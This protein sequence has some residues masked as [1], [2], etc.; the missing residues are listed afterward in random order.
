MFGA[1]DPSILAA[2]GIKIGPY[3]F[4][5]LPLTACGRPYVLNFYL[6]FSSR[7]KS[8][9][10]LF[11]LFFYNA[12]AR[13]PSGTY[14]QTPQKFSN[15]SQKRHMFRN[16]RGLR[17]FGVFLSA[18]RCPKS[19][20]LTTHRSRAPQHFVKCI[21]GAR[22]GKSIEQIARTFAKMFTR[23]FRAALCC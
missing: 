8:Y 12:R 17:F 16:F 11:F 10:C 2:A 21:F 6:L 23:S 14:I 1:V 5:F 9:C 22:M 4:S 19:E 18:K 3:F 20:T 13:A 15:N 7:D